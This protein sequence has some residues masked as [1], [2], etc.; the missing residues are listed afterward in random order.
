MYR[1]DLRKE[2]TEHVERGTDGE[3][4]RIAKERGGGGNVVW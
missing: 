3:G 1:F 2:N 4:R